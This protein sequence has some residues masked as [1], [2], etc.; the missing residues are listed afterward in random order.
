M[1]ALLQRVSQAKV[2]VDGATVG[3]IGRGLLVLLAVEPADTEVEAGKLIER[4]VRYRV[5]EDDAGRMNLSLLDT[6]GELLL[7]P[8]FT[9]AAD[10]GKGLRPSFT[11]AATPEQG[12][13]LFR[14]AVARAAAQLPG[15]VEL[16]RFGA[17]M[18]VSLTNDGPVTFWLRY[19]S[20]SAASPAD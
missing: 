16:G 13:R 10:T 6:G 20:R 17:H 15:K 8:Q 3:Q 1:I 4:L 14:Y 9:L 7:V 19:A 18:H 5:F 11:S 2:E 12:E